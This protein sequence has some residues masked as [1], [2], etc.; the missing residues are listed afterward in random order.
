MLI[1]DTDDV[2][3][4]CRRTLKSIC[5]RCWTKRIGPGHEIEG[6][7]GPDIGRWLSTLSRAP[8]GDDLKWI[9]R[10]TT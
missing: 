4:C 6:E 1:D 2:S 9:V 8:G 10:Y 7:P 5:P 3:G